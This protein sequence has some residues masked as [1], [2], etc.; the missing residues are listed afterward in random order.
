MEERKLSIRR[1]ILTTLLVA[2]TS[3]MCVIMVSFVGFTW[4][5]RTN[6]IE[7]LKNLAT[8]LAYNISPMIAFEDP[9][10]AKK[11]LDGLRQSSDIQRATIYRNDG[12]V[13]VSVTAEN[14]NNKIFSVHRDILS[15]DGRKLGRLTIDSKLSVY[16]TQI[17][18]ALVALFIT[19]CIL[20]IGIYL[21]SS[22]FQKS[23]SKPI[24]SLAKFTK[25][26]AKEKDY[27]LRVNA[28]ETEELDVLATSFN[29]MLKRIQDQDQ[30]LETNLKDLA[31]ELAE[32][33]E[34]EKMKEHLN[35]QLLQSQK[36]EVVGRLA[37]GVAHDFNNM[38]GV[39]IGRADL[40]LSGLADDH[41]LVPALK[42][43]LAAAEHSAT[44]TRQLLA[45]A[46]KQSVAP[47]IL[48]LNESVNITLKMLGR[49]IGESVDIVWEPSQDPWSIKIDPSQVDQILANLCVNAKDALKNSGTIRI[50]TANT[51]LDD[52]FCASYEIKSGQYVVLS[53]AD[54]GCGIPPEILNQIFEPFFTTKAVGQGT[55]LGLSTVYGIIQQNRGALTVES[56]VGVGTTFKLFF[57]RAI[58][59]RKK[60]RLLKA[61]AI[62]PG[63]H[64]KLLVVEDE[65]A[66]R[67]IAEELLRSLEYDVVSTGSPKVALNLGMSQDFD[68]LITDVVMPEMTGT[69]LALALR[70]AKPYLK[71]LFT[72]G[73]TADAITGEIDDATFLQ[74]PYTIRDL[75]TKVN[76]ILN[77]NQG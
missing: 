9:D 42:E 14:T 47:K 16:Y 25:R 27:S 5:L 22:K 77:P 72:S 38:L 10:A 65:T 24:L 8:V 64:Q 34:A 56:T 45:F 57:P 62:A 43:I 52:S 61:L 58:E 40:T 30:L 33:K 12:T 73:Y 54:S 67:E 31:R 55:G 23:V 49:L 4:S 17:H 51:I 18:W 11:T 63:N 76:N 7:D 37:G 28:H 13:L 41:P 21:L 15:D 68:L 74:K 1:K 36:M 19:F 66:L 39:I 53:V 46:R 20:A 29:E 3:G 69:D 26:I 75:A 50:S 70:Q 6:A 32:R 60:P 35:N 71:C 48:D 2:A 44:L 59:N